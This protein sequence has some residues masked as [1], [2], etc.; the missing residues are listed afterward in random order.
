MKPF[1]FGAEDENCQNRKE[2]AMR[3]L[4]TGFLTL[5]LAFPAQAKVV[6][7]AVE[8]RHDGAMYVGYLA[9]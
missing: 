3:V 4:L 2:T 8:Y 6:G 9:Y 7:K 5:A 1:N